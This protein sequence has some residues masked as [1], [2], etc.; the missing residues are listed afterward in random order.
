[1]TPLETR[2]LPGALWEKIPT[3]WIAWDI[4]LQRQL[5]LIVDPAVSPWRQIQW[6]TESKHGIFF[7]LIALGFAALSKRTLFAR[8]PFRMSRLFSILLFFV[9]LGAADLVSS[10]LKL[11]VG[12]LKPHV[13]FYNPNFTP[14]LSFPSNHAFN[15]AFA[16]ML[17]WSLCTPH[18]R[19][20]YRWIFLVGALIVMFIGTSRVFFGQ[21]YPLDI[22]A[23]WMLGAALGRLSA[24]FYRAVALFTNRKSTTPRQSNERPVT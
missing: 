19:R 21:H 9:W 3:E 10:R 1:M 20:E 18:A 15:T 14:A 24:S 11:F 5:D 16:W 22:L 2:S 4:S 13:N 12:R 8:A 23:G 7:G 6:W 17:L